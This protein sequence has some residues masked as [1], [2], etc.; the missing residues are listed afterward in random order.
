MSEQIPLEL[1]SNFISILLVVALI[2]KYIQYK[3]RID[4][5]EKL[6]NLKKED[7]LTN[8]DKKY[9][10]ENEKEYQEKYLKAQANIKLMNPVFILIAG[11]LMVYLPFTEAMIHLNVVVVAVIFIQLDRIHK[12]NTY[13]LLHGLKKEN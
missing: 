1:V 3:K 6:D 5:I 11:I 8:D 13:E 12:K 2:Y 7:K 9:I 10:D 4:V